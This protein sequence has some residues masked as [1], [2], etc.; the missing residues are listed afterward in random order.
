MADQNERVYYQPSLEKSILQTKVL[1]I[2]VRKHLYFIGAVL[3]ITIW[4]IIFR[5]YLFNKS[6]EMILDI[7]NGGRDPWT[8]SF[9]RCFKLIGDAKFVYMVLIFVYIFGSK[10]LAYHY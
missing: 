4:N 3:A 6:L 9:F 1:G 10:A 7:Q 5:D 8:F 2:Q